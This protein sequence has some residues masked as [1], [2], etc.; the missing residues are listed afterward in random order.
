[1]RLLG[2]LRVEPVRCTCVYLFTAQ[3]LSD[4][5]FCQPSVIRKRYGRMAL[6]SFG[7]DV[8]KEEEERILD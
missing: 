1:L 3:S 5:L 8:L 7:F 4:L 2:S 6:I